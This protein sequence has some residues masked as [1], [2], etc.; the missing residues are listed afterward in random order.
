M[1]RRIWLAA[2]TITLLLGVGLAES[3]GQT[4]TH[5]QS[6][7]PSGAPTS[8]QFGLSV[9]ISGDTAVVGA[10]AASAMVN[11]VTISAISIDAWGTVTADVV[12][13]SANANAS[14]TLRVTDTTG[15]FAE[16]TL[17]VRNLVIFGG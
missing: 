14:F 12:A 2:T 8:N 7:W 4:F 3:S 1:R 13:V 16:A 17:V 6:F 11:G 10:Q 5:Q 15:L 9:A